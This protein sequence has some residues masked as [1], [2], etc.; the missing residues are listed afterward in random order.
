MGVTS[1]VLMR[2]SIE[3]S[4]GKP[5]N[6]HTAHRLIRDHRRRFEFGNALIEIGLLLC[7]RRDDLLHMVF[8]VPCLLGCE[9]LQ[10]I[11]GNHVIA[12]RIMDC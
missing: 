9:F 3:Q 11:P 8:Q 1:M 4:V 12:D 10:D 6:N 7:K 5:A 2:S